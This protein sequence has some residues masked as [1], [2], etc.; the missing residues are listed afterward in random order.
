[1]KISQKGSKSKLAHSELPSVSA[2]AI[3][4]QPTGKPV[5]RL[6]LDLRLTNEED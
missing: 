1:M 4:R 3:F 5:D 6:V 2:I